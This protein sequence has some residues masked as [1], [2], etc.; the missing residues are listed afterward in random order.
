MS[1]GFAVARQL[2]P[3][4]R[5][6]ALVNGKRE[7]LL[8]VGIALSPEY[9][10][11]GMGGSP[12]QRGF[13]VF[14]VD[15]QAL[16][17]AYNME[18]AFN[19]VAVRLAPGATEGPVIDHL[20]RLLAPFGGITAHGRDLQMSHMI[21]DSEIKEQRVLGTAACSLETKLPCTMSI[22]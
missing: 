8:I 20:N 21:L 2:K 4:D 7:V 1:E 14:W 3:G 11:A 19:Q 16:A 18:G 6:N 9:I 17:A 15:R 10:F 5:L 22:L 12:D 13:G